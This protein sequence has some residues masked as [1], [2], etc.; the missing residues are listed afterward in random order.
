VKELY[1][2]AQLS[3]VIARLDRAIEYPALSPLRH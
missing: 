1:V 2:A 3:P